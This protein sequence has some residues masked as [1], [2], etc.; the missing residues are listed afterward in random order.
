MS[1]EKQRAGDS[2]IWEA[3]KSLRADHYAFKE[4]TNNRMTS[5]EVWRHEYNKAHE[6]LTQ[7]LTEANV[8]LDILHTELSEARGALRVIK[9]ALGVTGGGSVIAATK[10]IGII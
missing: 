3:I 1:E 2:H 6:L 10:Y 4:K 7:K 8:K 9:W 5:F